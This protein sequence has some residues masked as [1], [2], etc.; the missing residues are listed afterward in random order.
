MKEKTPKH[1]LRKIYMEVLRGYTKTTVPKFGAFYIKHLDLFASEEI[2]EKK[3]EYEEHAQSKGLPTAKEKLAELEKD[4]LWSP[5]KER[6]IKNLESM[7]ERLKITKSIFVLQADRDSIQKQIR[8]A[9]KEHEDLIH[10]KAELMGYTCDSYAFK[11]MNEFFIFNTSYKTPDLKDLFFDKNTFDELHEMEVSILASHYGKVGESYGEK[12]LKRIAL[13]GF[14]L[15][16]FYLC[17]NN[18]FTFF[19]NPVVELTYNQS[20]LFSYGTYFK[21]LLQELKHEPDPE[22]MDDPDK[23]VELFNVSKNIIIRKTY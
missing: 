9:I 14:F 4:D 18:P 15:N 12:N 6:D 5:Q 13:S 11:K 16:S 10:E 3:R 20:E 2:D 23:L 1:L 19:G 7:I 22:T 21:H 8:D 17:K